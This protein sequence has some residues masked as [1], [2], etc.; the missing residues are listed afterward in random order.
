[1]FYLIF[2]SLE[3]RTEMIAKLKKKNIFAVFHYLSLHS[4]PYFKDMYR[5]EKLLNSDRFS[6]CLLRLPLYY[7][8]SIEEVDRILD[9]IV[10]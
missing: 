8:L 1:M 9:V 7:E 3:H 5:G 10:S 6:D 2:E 4:S